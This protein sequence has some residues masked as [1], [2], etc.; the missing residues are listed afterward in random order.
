MNDYQV[1]TALRKAIECMTD[2]QFAQVEEDATKL[3]HPETGQ[4]FCELAAEY[5]AAGVKRNPLDIY[6]ISRIARR[7]PGL[8]QALRA[9][10]PDEDDLK[11]IAEGWQRPPTPRDPKDYE[12]EMCAIAEMAAAA[13]DAAEAEKGKYSVDW[14][15]AHAE[16]WAACCTLY[17]SAANVDGLL[18]LPE[19]QLWEE[20]VDALSALLSLFA[21]PDAAVAVPVE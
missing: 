20:R 10:F 14:L 9:Y 17:M 13:L 3:I 16:R 5:F 2:L 7:Y 1:Q 12:G 19:R 21:N 6:R 18:N 11:D 15:I 4:S 8:A